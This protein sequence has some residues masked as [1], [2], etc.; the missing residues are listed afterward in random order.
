MEN[1]LNYF[2][3][4]GKR[5]LAAKTK[6]H[7]HEEPKCQNAKSV[8]RHFSEPK[9]IRSGFKSEDIIDSSLDR[10]IVSLEFC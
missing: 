10:G 3:D 4:V 8:A 2:Y 9:E 1:S 6:L 7:N 5:V